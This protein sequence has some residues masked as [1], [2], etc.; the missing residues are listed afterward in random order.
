MAHRRGAWP[1]LLV[2]LVATCFGATCTSPTGPPTAPSLLLPFTIINNVSYAFFCGRW[3]VQPPATRTLIDLFLFGSSAD[4]PGEAQVAAVE[5]AGGQVVHRFNAPAVRAVID[6]DALPALGALPDATVD[7]ARTV[8]DS[9]AFLVDVV[10]VFDHTPTADDVAAMTNGGGVIIRTIAF[11]N[12]TLLEGNVAD[13]TLPGLRARPGVTEVDLD[14]FGCLVG[15]ELGRGGSFERRSQTYSGPK[16]QRAAGPGL[17]PAM[18]PHVR[19]RTNTSG[20]R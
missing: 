13:A 17:G 9:S 15:G 4:A 14:V 20:Q 2:G 18:G 7:W 6:V 5:A 11:S 12:F 10:V 8:T 3:G 16:S 19:V 1:A